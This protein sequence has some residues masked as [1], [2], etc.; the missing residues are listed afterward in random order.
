MN[1][2]NRYF[3]LTV[4][5]IGTVSFT[6]EESR[7]HVFSRNAGKKLKNIGGAVVAKRSLYIMFTC[8]EWKMKNSM[9][10][11][12]AFMNRKL[13]LR[14]IRKL[15]KSKDIELD[16]GEM[17]ELGDWDISEI[18]SRFIYLYIE[19]MEPNSVL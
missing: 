18:N 16:Y 1:K 17:K 12:G 7:N 9:R 13:L 8:D 3:P 10:L 14:E 11:H 5:S 6:S 19:E 2:K 15:K 4:P